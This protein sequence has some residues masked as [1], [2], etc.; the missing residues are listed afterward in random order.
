[1]AELLLINPR[2]RRKGARKSTKRRVRRTVSH[3]VA[4][5][6]RRRRRNPI[7]AVRTIRRRVMHSRRV[8]HRR[9]RNPISLGRSSS[10][11]LSM[12]KDAMIGG[13]GTVAFDLLMGQLNKFLPASMQRSAT[14]VGMGDA[15]KAVATVAV[16]SFA[17][18]SM[19]PLVRKMALGSLTV[20][21]AEIARSYLPASLPV[22]GVGYAMP[23]RIVQG[24][25]RI[26]PNFTRMGAYTGGRTPLLAAYTGGASPLLSGNR[27]AREREG[28]IL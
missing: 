2:S 23:S 27:T 19:R 14:G 12:F 21:V 1:M 8:H 9:R 13:A 5:P 17:P 28:A 20:Q 7:A 22:A 6:R 24:S 26:G 3:S 18:R 15:V 4:A 16:A 11:W 10:G 25:S